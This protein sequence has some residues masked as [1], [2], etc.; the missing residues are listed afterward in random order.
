MPAATRVTVVPATLHAGELVENVTGLPDAPPVA[1]TV[2][3]P[4]VIRLSA[5]GA[6][7]IVWPAWVTEAVWVT[8]VAGP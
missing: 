4:S 2:N 1:A 6:K 8:R 7:L 5:S 3:A